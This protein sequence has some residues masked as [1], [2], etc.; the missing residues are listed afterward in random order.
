MFHE[1]VDRIRR[2]SYHLEAE[3]A[4]INILSNIEKMLM[5]AI[6]FLQ[7]AL[8]VVSG[9]TYLYLHRSEVLLCIRGVREPRP[10]SIEGK[11]AGRG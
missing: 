9:G 8:Y 11:A 6:A 7:G 3:V 1:S 4:F 2:Y 5:I 10:G